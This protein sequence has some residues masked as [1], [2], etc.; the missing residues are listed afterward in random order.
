MGLAEQVGERSRSPVFVV[1]SPR[2][3]TTLL[4]DML[5]S[6]GGFA[7]YLGESNIF[8]L[9]A[10]R[11]GDLSIRANREKMLNAWLGSR[12]FRVSGLEA[13]QITEKILNDCRNAGDFLRIVMDELARQQGASRWASN[14]PEEIL[15]VQRIKETIPEALFIH[16]IRDGRD[17]GVSLAEKHYLRPFPWKDRETAEGA[18][19]YW[20]WI[21]Q[22]GRAAGATLGKAYIEVRF[23]EL[24]SDPRT[25][26]QCLSS[27]LDHDLDYDRIQRNA[28]GTVAR[29]NTSF[30]RKKAV[31]FNPVGRWKRQLTAE[32]L[33]NVEDLVGSTLAG[34]GY[35]LADSARADCRTI[36]VVWN[37]ILYRQ[38]FR[39][40]QQWKKN[41]VVR[42]IRPP[43]TS[44]Q[45]DEYVI[46]DDRKRKVEIV[47]EVGDQ[48]SGPVP[49]KAAIPR[50]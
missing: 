45:I 12:L 28:V 4:Y 42:F 34:L 33:A 35:P 13:H 31:D 1:G 32:R 20:E 3:G 9:V 46:V 44:Q 39:M 7:Q 21:V 18:A 14:A 29:P 6:A 47:S 38:F 36:G 11:F 17:V 2:S 22:K 48:S 37:R 16:M 5:L 41:R 27:F 25:A 50:S 26:L 43:L 30:K 24:V 10:P 49:L 19:L 15:H 8:N 23:E 40:K